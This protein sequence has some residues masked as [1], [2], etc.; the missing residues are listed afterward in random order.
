MLMVVVKNFK[1]LVFLY[2]CSYYRYH[3]CSR[4]QI[5][6]VAIVHA[7]YIF[8]KSPLTKRLYTNVVKLNQEMHQTYLPA[9]TQTSGS[10]HRIQSEKVNVF[11]FFGDCSQCSS[12]HTKLTQVNV[13]LVKL[14]QPQLLT[15]ACNVCGAPS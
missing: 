7:L 12:L 6:V 1:V 14:I 3:R 4:C 15:G 2:C 10:V 5:V 9:Q 13:I 8:C 11:V